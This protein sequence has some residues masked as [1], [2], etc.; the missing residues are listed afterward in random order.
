MIRIYNRFNGELIKEFNSETLKGA[1]LR[2]ADLR[3]ADLRDANLRC[4]DVT[5]DI[6]AGL[7]CPE[8]QITSINKGV[9]WY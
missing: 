9:E 7:L 6:L 5:R 3:D 8:A 2:D 1:D 4:A